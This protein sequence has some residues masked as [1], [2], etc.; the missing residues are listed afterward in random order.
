[1]FPARCNGRQR[2]AAGAICLKK[3]ARAL[4][5]LRAREIFLARGDPPCITRGIGHRAAPIAPEVIAQR[6]LHVRAG[7]DRAIEQRVGVVDIQPE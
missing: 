4:L 6:Y 5:E 1:M 7:A 3:S 2:V